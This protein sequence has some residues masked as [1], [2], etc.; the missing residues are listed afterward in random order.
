MRLQPEWSL[1]LWRFITGRALSAVVRPAPRHGRRLRYEACLSRPLQALSK[2]ILIIIANSNLPGQG[3]L[4]QVREHNLQN[5][6]HKVIDENIHTILNRVQ[7]LEY[8]P[9]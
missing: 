5:F 4:G 3:P 7:H 6:E 1:H 8:I 2:A 9:S